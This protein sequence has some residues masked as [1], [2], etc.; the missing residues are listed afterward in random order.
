MTSTEASM[1]PIVAPPPMPPQPRPP[2]AWKFIGT[3]LWGL[4]V[5]VAMFAGQLSVLAYFVL[6]DP[7]PFSFDKV[8][9]HAGDGLT[10]ALSVVAGLPM[11]L[12][13]LWIPIRLSGVL[14][15]DYLALRWIS[16]RHL[17]LGIAA[18]V[19]LVLG[20]EGVFYAM[21]HETSAGFVVDVLN[22]AR[23]E[24]ALWLLVIAICVVAPVTEEL[25]TRGFLYRGWSESVLRPAGAIV[26]S[27]LVWTAMH[28][29]YDPFFFAEVFSIGLLF[30][31]LRYRSGSILLTVI[32]HGL[33]NL[34]ATLQTLW[35]A[36]HS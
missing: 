34:A 18:L 31:Y 20:W 7:A 4:A 28:L 35:I 26:L 21:G 19:A 33:N 32:L 25:L 23:A 8:T 10:V 6:T 36:G 3:S 14:L 11:A 29:Q 15:A 16:W 22:S 13:A 17:L 27:S 12:L 9:E 2:Q 30:G 1:Y 5:F 24:G